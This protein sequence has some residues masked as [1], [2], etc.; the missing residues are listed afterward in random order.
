M[1]V[2][3]LTLEDA[4][5]LVR[6]LDAGTVRD[7][8]L[9]DSALHRPGSSFFG[10]EVYPE[11]ELKA[12]ALL[13]SIVKNHPLIDGNERLAWLATVVFLD[14]NGHRCTLDRQ[15]AVRLVVDV[16]KADLDIAEIAARLA[17]EPG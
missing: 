10:T 11:L 12:A 2:T 17:I 4:L 6:S 14:L 1:T 16:A 3:Y 7:L 9:L 13:Q 15:T 8:G 5:G